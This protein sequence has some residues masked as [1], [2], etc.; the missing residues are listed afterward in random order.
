[1]SFILSEEKYDKAKKLYPIARLKTKSKLKYIYYIEDK[2]PKIDEK[3]LQGLS[4]SDKEIIQQCIENNEEPD[5]DRLEKIYYEIL[6]KM[7]HKK[8]RYVVPKGKTLEVLPDFNRIQKIYISAQS[9]AG[10]STWASNWIRRYLEHYKDNEFYV[11]SCVDED[12]VIDKLHPV[13]VDLDNVLS[14]PI[15]VQNELQDSV[16]LIDD[17]ACITDI[18]TRKYVINLLNSIAQIGRHARCTLLNIVHNTLDRHNSKTILTEA[19]S[20]VIFC[21]AGS[22]KQ[23]IDY[24]E[25]YCNF[26]KDLIKKILNLPSRFVCITRTYPNMII[27][28]RGIFV[29]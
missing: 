7:K 16:V 5:D 11:L 10:K 12:D 2:I 8:K 14:D 20:V 18:Q 3:F 24:M 6:D 13:R 23:N 9:G 4:H 25:R 26:D 21:R 17:C 22:N 28:E 29:V 1:M 15:D 19:T 27:H